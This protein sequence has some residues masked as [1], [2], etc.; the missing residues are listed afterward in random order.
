MVRKIIPFILFSIFMVQMSMNPLY[1]QHRKTQ[2]RF[3]AYAHIGFNA[4]QIDGDQS[5]PYNR[6]HLMGGVGTQFPLSKD[7]RNPFR[8]IVE[9]NYSGKGS[10]VKQI[11]RTIDLSYVEIPLMLGYNAGSFRLAAGFAPAILIK[12]HVED[13]NV[14]D[15]IQSDN[16]RKWDRLPFLLD[17]QYKTTDHLWLGVRFQTSLLTIARQSGSGTYRISRSN[18]GQFHKLLSLSVGYKF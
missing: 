5:G 12:S 15:P 10:Y 7:S 9:L 2:N 8:M 1:A 13:H 4:C 17:F 14:F 6:F 16:Y 11:D 18:M 3:D